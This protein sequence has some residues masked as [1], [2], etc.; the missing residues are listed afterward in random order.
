MILDNEPCRP[1]DAARKGLNLGEGAGF[2]VLESREHA[3]SRGAS[4]RAYLSGWGNSC[5]AYHQTASSP[6]G[7]GAFAAMQQALEVAGL[8]P[9]DIGYV[10]AHGTGTQSNDSSEGVA[11][12][13]L[14]GNRM[15]FV[16]STKCYT[17]HA[18]SAAGGLEAVIS[19]LCLQKGFV[20]ANLRFENRDQNLSFSPVDHSVKDVRL[21]H[22]L[23]NSFGFG[24]NDSS[25]IFSSAE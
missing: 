23:S 20:P 11:L 12:M 19:I 18:T 15:P 17:G 5:D 8:E 16:G 13:R 7:A 24:G 4:I 3:L 6:D 25:L 21:T 9:S 22:V 1:F 14:F 10:N 2:V